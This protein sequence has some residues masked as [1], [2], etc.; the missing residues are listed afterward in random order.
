M[1]R[2][3]VFVRCIQMDGSCCGATCSR[4][5]CVAL[6]GLT[7]YY[8][9]S[10]PV[11]QQTPSSQTTPVQV[12]DEL[13][14]SCAVQYR[15]RWAPTMRWTFSDGGVIASS[16][17]GR[18]GESV[19]HTIRFD[20][21]AQHSGRTLHCRTFFAPPLDPP[22]AANNASNVPDYEFEFE[23]DTIAVQSE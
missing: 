20:A 13:V 10:S 6:R 18:A 14:F 19:N 11:C 9:E 15:G 12:G 1:S 8:S 23:S 17:A 7:L 21:R 22:P 4:D 3:V 16:D 2:S 5:A